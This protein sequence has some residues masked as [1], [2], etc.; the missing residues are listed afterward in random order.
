ME[1]DFECRAILLSIERVFGRRG[2]SSRGRGRRRQR[3]EL[4]LS[5]RLVSPGANVSLH[6]GLANSGRASAQAPYLAMDIS[7]PFRVSPFGLDSNCGFHSRRSV[8][9]AQ[10]YSEQFVATA[11]FVVHPGMTLDAARIDRGFAASAELPTDDLVIRYRRAARDY[12]LEQGVRTISRAR[13]R[14]ATYEGESV[15]TTTLHRGLKV[16]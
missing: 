4:E 15:H 10:E 12:P 3:P 16:Q 13:L 1:T 6:I 14:G 9:K 5:V 11:E 2:F 8:A 7:P